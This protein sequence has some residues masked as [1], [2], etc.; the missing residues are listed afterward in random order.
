MNRIHTA[1][2]ALTAAI[3]CFVGGWA[4]FAPAAFYDSFPG[5]LGQWVATDGPYNEHLVRD[6]GAFYLALGAA[7]VAGF[8]WRSP[9][10]VRLLG[11]AWTVFGALH[12]WYHATHLD[13]LDTDAAI[14]T[15]VSL[16]LSLGLGILLLIPARGSGAGSAATAGVAEPA[17]SVL[18]DARRAREEVAR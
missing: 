12:L 2:L 5:V 8:A 4:S 16:T 13:H 3:A 14:G 7:S 18:P 6:V 9:A 10:V 11:L 15:A 1:A 17:A